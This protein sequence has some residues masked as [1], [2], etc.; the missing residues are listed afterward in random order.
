[1]TSTQADDR[2]E[3]PDGLVRHLQDLVDESLRHSSYGVVLGVESSRLERLV[4]VSGF[5]DA[6]RTVPVTRD[7]LFQIGSQTKTI[8]AA[9]VC[10]LIK[11]GALSLD[12]PV[13][14]VIEGFPGDE[15]VTVA[16]LLNH[17][18]GI[19][20]ASRLLDPI[21]RIVDYPLSFE[22]RMLLTKVAG[23][24]FPSGS[25]WE[26]NNAG[27]W[28]LGEIVSTITGL[29]YSDYLTKHILEPLGI[30]NTFVGSDYRFPMDRM[31]RGFHMDAK[32]VLTETSDHLCLAE[33]GA[34][35][36]IVSSIDDMLTWLS[37]L[38]EVEPKT[39]VTLEDLTAV[40]VDCSTDT[41]SNASE[42]GL[43]VQKY[44]IAGRECWGHGGAMCG[45][46]SF[47][48]IE[49]LSGTRICVLSNK[50][51]SAGPAWMALQAVGFSLIP[52]VM[53]VLREYRSGE[54]GEETVHV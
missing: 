8:T 6:E 49:P 2:M 46:M 50:L 9:C 33:A 25:G 15:Q 37:S 32:G 20:N 18:S 40:S 3:A 17:T 23:V 24:S 39:S 54:P 30:D 38:I 29:A 1:M 11:E 4:V 28:A 14:D 45:Y 5:A 26:Y 52:L 44:R 22:E 47:G 10:R 53:C 13:V 12:T 36:D 7:H 41:Y 19:G 21:N 48:V 51:T 42:Y 16:S 35:G 34:A 31:A 27:Y 43:G